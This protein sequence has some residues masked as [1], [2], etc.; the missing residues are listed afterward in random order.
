MEKQIAAWEYIN[1]LANEGNKVKIILG[2]HKVFRVSGRVLCGY[3]QRVTHSVSDNIFVLTPSKVFDKNK[4]WKY[5]QVIDNSI[6]IAEIWL[7]GKKIF[8]DIRF[9]KL[10]LSIIEL[11]NI[12]TIQHPIYAFE[13]Y[14]YNPEFGYSTLRVFNT[15]LEAKRYIEY[16]TGSRMNLSGRKS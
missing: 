14:S 15:E 4:L 16:L 11:H 5:D 8:E 10:R 9:T 1:Q 12:G 13:V 2:D 7:N 3:L 6:C